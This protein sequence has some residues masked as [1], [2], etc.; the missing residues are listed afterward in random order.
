M[1]TYIL[2]VNWIICVLTANISAG[3]AVFVSAIQDIKPLRY[4][5]K[6]YRFC[7]CLLTIASITLVIGTIMFIIGG[8][9]GWL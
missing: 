2:I 5:K 8:I 7:I 4:F 9:K 1:Y 6:T 3:I